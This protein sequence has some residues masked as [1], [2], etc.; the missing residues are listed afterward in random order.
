M[1]IRGSM[2]TAFME[3]MIASAAGADV[4]TS[5][6][7]VAAHFAQPAKPEASGEDDDD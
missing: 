1:E 5:L 2:L 7:R 4:E 6:Q 3:P